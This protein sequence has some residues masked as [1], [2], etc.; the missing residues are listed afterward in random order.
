MNSK[1]SEITAYCRKHGVKLVAVSKTKTPAEVLEVYQQGQRCFGENK[2]QELLQK[3]EA[4][5]SD[6]EWHM[7]GHLQSNKVK[8][9]VTVVSLIQSVDSRKLLLEI[10][11]EAKKKEQIM[12]VLL[13]VHIAEEET[14]F[15]LSY[16]EAQALIRDSGQNI[17]QN[18]A[19]CGLMG[20]ATL[21]D[22]DAQISN[23][24]RKLKTFF[25]AM[26]VVKQDPEF[27]ILS[28]GMSSDYRIAVEEGSNMIRIG[29]A[30]FGRRS[31]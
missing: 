13:Q 8:Q 4:L 3:H 11:K 7:I 22:N 14:K 31:A 29:T 27:K 17:F 19:I 16:A 26:K 18:V 23:E 25:E 20:M 12:K 30:I 24:F 2:V 9:L 21:T 15:G 6:I 1:Y 5:P 28:I 10:D